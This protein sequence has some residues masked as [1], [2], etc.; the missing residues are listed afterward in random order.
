MQKMLAISHTKF[1]EVISIGKVFLHKSFNS[2]SFLTLTLLILLKF[3]ALSWGQLSI[4]YLSLLVLQQTSLFSLETFCQHSILAKPTDAITIWSDAIRVRLGISCLLVALLTFLKIPIAILALTAVYLILNVYNEAFKVAAKI[5]DK[6]NTWSL[7][8]WASSWVAYGWIFIIKAQ[9][10]FHDLLVILTVSQCLRFAL[11]N[12]QFYQKYKV[13]LLPR[14]DFTQLRLSGSYFLRSS[15]VRL[16]Y[17][18]P[19]F[20]AVFLL[21]S[22]AMSSFHLLLL[23]T[24]VGCSIAHQL[25]IHGV[26]NFNEWNREAIKVQILKMLIVGTLMGLMWVLLGIFLSNKIPFSITSPWWMIP[27]FIILVFTY[28]QLP[29][30]HALL[31]EREEN[32]IIQIYTLII[33]L[34]ATLGYWFLSQQEIVLCLWILG[35]TA[36][37]QTLLYMKALSRIL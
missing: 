31:K 10:Q 36:V 30:L 13:P 25:G 32:R 37:L 20:L 8:S 33:L 3:G 23:W 16:N 26:L 35:A 11:L 22:I 28:V 5:E 15:V 18:T 34:Q 29:L 4:Q 2:I 12:I 9:I 24:F 27:V 19:F 7:I 1:E 6:I 14:T 17:K 21:G